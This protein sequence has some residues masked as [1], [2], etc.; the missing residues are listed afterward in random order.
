MSTLLISHRACIAHDTGETHPER[1]DRLRSI[2]RALEAEEFY[3][4]HRDEAPFGDI[5][6]V[7]RVHDPDYVDHVRAHVP[8]SGHYQLDGDTFLSPGSWEAAL[9][10]VGGICHAV[11]A[12]TEGPE[13]NAFVATRPPGHHAEHDKAMGFCLFN[14]AAIAAQFAREKYGIK[15]VAV[16]DF[17]VHHGNGTQHMFENDPDLFYIS[18]HQWP[19]YPG[20]G[21]PQERGMHH[22]IL[23]VPLAEGAGGEEIKQAFEGAVIP[24]L[25]SMRPELL[26]ISAG[27]DAHANDPLGG[28]NLTA[29][30]YAW[31]TEQLLQFAQDYCDNRV[32][33]VLEGG[34]ELGGLSGSVAA[35]V[36]TL[37]TA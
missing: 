7:K 5:E 8:R 32:V 2:Q 14:N 6:L 35:H 33:S 13:R 3:L 28:L 20:T 9:R 11:E 27:F 19:L 10:A 21:A 36:R 1:P 23:N 26:I 17:D 24:E 34:Y 29:P 31:M 30:D 15:R 16:M 12:V 22:N 4:L 18:T 37:M 25:T